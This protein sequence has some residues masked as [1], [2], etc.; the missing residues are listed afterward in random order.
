MLLRLGI[1]NH[2]Q[3]YLDSGIEV[4]LA[5]AAIGK[6]EWLTMEKQSGIRGLENAV[7]ADK[8]RMLKR[9]AVQRTLWQDGVTLTSRRVSKSALVRN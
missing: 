2:N 7:V 5:S 9:P 6:R 3:K 1:A 8:D 4:I